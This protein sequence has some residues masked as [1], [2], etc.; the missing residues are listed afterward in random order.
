MILGYACNI[1]N[2]CVLIYSSTFTEVLLAH[3][4]ELWTRD[5]KKTSCIIFPTIHHN[6]SHILPVDTLYIFQTYWK[7][8]GFITR[9]KRNKFIPAGQQTSHPG[10]F[11][12]VDSDASRSPRT[13]HR[14]PPP[15]CECVTKGGELENNMHYMRM[16]NIQDVNYTQPLSQPYNQILETCIQI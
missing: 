11:H 7:N 9:V 1:N 4:Q 2:V 5:G 6:T 12:W 13:C 16:H 14:H 8:H 3:P 10:G 15:G